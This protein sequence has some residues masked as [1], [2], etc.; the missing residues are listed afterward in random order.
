MAKFRVCMSWGSREEGTFEEVFEARNEEEAESL[1]RR[2]M[3][4]SESSTP[5]DESDLLRRIEE[6]QDYW[7]LIHCIPEPDHEKTI[8]TL[9]QALA[10]CKAKFEETAGFYRGLASTTGADTLESAASCERMASQIGALL[11]DE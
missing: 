9:R 6:N 3:A 4:Y 5:D 10:L 8:S 7:F 11:R 1:C 2:A